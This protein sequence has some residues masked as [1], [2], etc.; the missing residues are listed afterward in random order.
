MTAR[1]SDPLRVLL[2]S[3]AYRPYLSGVSEHVHDLAAQLRARG[4]AVSLLTASYSLPS[5]EADPDYVTRIGRALVI[6]HGPG[7]F[8]LP[9]GIRLAAQVKDYM[10]RNMF[11][12]I[13]C[14]GIFPPEI[15]YW[16]TLYA[17]APVVTSFHWSFVGT[18][19]LRA[20][21]RMVFPRLN[22]RLAARIAVSEACRDWVRLWFP[23][24]YHIIHNGID[25][26]RFKPG[27]QPPASLADDRPSILYVGRLDRRKGL[28]MLLEA[29]PG[30]IG[31]VP[32]AK[33]VV[34]GP[35][36]LES[37]CRSRCR[38]LGIAEAVNFEGPVRSERLPGYY[39]NS[40]VYVS[41][42]VGRE[43]MGI[44]LVEAMACGRAVIASDIAAYNEVI[45][46]GVNGLLV[47]EHNPT[48][49]CETVTRVLTDPALRGRL[50]QAAMDRARDFAWPRIAERIE[51]VYREALR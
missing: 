14:H 43:S 5:T 44:V 47:P 3:A 2:V 38:E 29:M 21:F 40:T 32:D 27:A 17:R 1:P 24:D 49:L 45:Q 46:T 10:R 50:E 25:T 12:V 11:D 28:P 30:V 26:D 33:L 16:A 13:H 7:H 23:G 9:V 8:T 36:P 4:H 19:P 42:S 6:R 15:A 37:D 31:Q 35:G 41:P 22:R 39:G 20:L 48:T 34:V 18:G 51:Q